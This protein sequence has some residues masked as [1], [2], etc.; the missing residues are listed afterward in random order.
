MTK[1]IA[2]RGYTKNNPENTLSAFEEALSAGAHA[3]E[4]DVHLTS[5][6]ELVVHHDYYLGN[7][8]NGEGIIPDKDLSYI[9]TL[10]IGNKDK[11]PSLEDV[12]KL[13]GNKLQYEIELKGFTE[14]FLLKVLSLVKRYELLDVI[15]FT[16][17]HVYALTK[18][19]S[20][21]ALAKTGTFVAPLPVWMDKEL[22][23]TLAI[24]NALLGNID[25]LHCPI[26]L[27]DNEF[28]KKAHIRN[29]VVHAADC[30][31]EESILVAMSAGVDQFSTNEL[32]LALA[33]SNQ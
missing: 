25:V 16:S 12:F 5:D 22:G 6:G 33:L 14:Q 32:E 1:V 15:E 8:D 19:K 9:Q 7:P 26:E 18:L 17:P 3:I 10:T 11:I 27:I 21:E 29:L 23:Q 24:N 31:T 28:I 2:H 13:I 30:D 4:L 20:L